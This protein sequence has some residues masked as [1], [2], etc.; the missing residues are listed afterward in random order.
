MFMLCL[1]FNPPVTCSESSF[2]LNLSVTFKSPLRWN[3]R[4]HLN[5]AHVKANLSQQ[6]RRHE[7]KELAAMDGGR[8]LCDGTRAFSPPCPM[9]PKVAIL[10]Q[11]SLGCI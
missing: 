7:M 1:D 8:G 3:R 11:R 10:F 4:M 5:F 6:P 2:V 9:L